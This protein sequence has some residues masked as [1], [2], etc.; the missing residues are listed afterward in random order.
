MKSVWMSLSTIFVRNGV[1]NGR[2]SHPH[3]TFVKVSLPLDLHSHRD[4]SDRLWTLGHNLLDLSR[5]SETHYYSAVN[6]STIWGIACLPAD[7][8]PLNLNRKLGSLRDAPA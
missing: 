6:N 4:V 7:L 2:L 8:P 5:F 1:C 3:E